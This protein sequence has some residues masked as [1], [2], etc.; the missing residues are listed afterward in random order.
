MELIKRPRH[1]I[2]AQGRQGRR[3]SRAVVSSSTAP[4]LASVGHVPVQTGI[5]LV[6]G[7][8]DAGELLDF[9]SQTATISEKVLLEGAVVPGFEKSVRSSAAIKSLTF[10]GDPHTVDRL[11]ELLAR[12]R[13]LSWSDSQTSAFS[14]LESDSAIF[15]MAG[16]GPAFGGVLKDL[17][18][19]L[20][21]K[22]AVFEDSDKADSDGSRTRERDNDSVLALT[23]AYRADFLSSPTNF[24]FSTPAFSSDY[25]GT[26]NKYSSQI[27]DQTGKVSMFLRPLFRQKAKRSFA[28]RILNNGR[29]FESY[30][31]GAVLEK[32]EFGRVTQIR[33]RSGASISIYYDR[34]GSPEGFVRI[35]EKGKTH[36]IAECDR[37][38]VVVR[39][40]HGRP[41]A[42]GDSLS[43]D[44][45]GCLS[46]CRSDGQFWSV[47]LVYGRHIERRRL[48]DE[49]GLWHILT[50]IFAADGFRMVT[51]FQKV[52]ESPR[53]VGVVTIEAANQ[54]WTNAPLATGSFRFYG[55]DGS[56]I[57]FISEDAL[58]NLQPTHVWSPGTR[59]V[60]VVWKG[61]HQAGTAWDS[62]QE[63][64][65]S[66]LSR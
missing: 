45:R 13:G 30:D 16:S 40:E 62:V 50:G 66:Y 52:T 31:T 47:D 46:I 6:N 20:S 3:S 24:S 9:L 34:D 12:S 37:Q 18:D 1:Q 59:Q 17:N 2:R 5:A 55:R 25:L 65:S 32:D 61:R 7:G 41:R 35:D 15:D 49:A 8:Q 63:Y 29:R 10:D 54:W 38:G 27:S 19:W 51:L 28:T 22:H 57:E 58:T 60:D 21:A 4:H 64:V 11:N 56:V 33:S 14:G 36:S 53:D 44:Q 48:S 42:Q 39:D 26:T 43:V 23:K